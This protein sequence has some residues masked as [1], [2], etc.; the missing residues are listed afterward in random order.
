MSGLTFGIFDWLDDA[1]RGLAETWEQRLR[2]LEYADRSDLARHAA[3]GDFDTFVGQG[4][5]TYGSPATIRAKLQ[6]HLDLTG[7][8]YLVGVFAFGGLTE[9]QVMRSLHLFTTEVIPRLA[10]HAG[11]Q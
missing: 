5:L 11:G 6:L 8:D 7:A 1:R 10:A 3:R 9:R 2:M 4:L